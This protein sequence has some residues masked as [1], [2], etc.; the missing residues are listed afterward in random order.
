M[1][2]RTTFLLTAIS[3]GVP[4]G[5]AHAPGGLPK[6]YCEDP[7][8]WNLHDYAPVANGVF[9]LG[10]DGNIVGDC[11]GDGVPSDFD[12]HAEWAQGGATLLVES[13]D[14]V[15]SGAIACHGADAHHPFFGPIAAY[16]L[17]LGFTV[18]FFVGA[19]TVTLTPPTDPTEPVCG[20]ALVDIAGSC[21][22][23]CFVTFGPGLDGA[24]AVSVGAIASGL[25]G[26]VGHVCSPSCGEGTEPEWDYSLGVPLSDCTD[27]LDNDGD[28]GRDWI[29]LLFGSPDPGCGLPVDNEGS[30]G[31]ALT[32]VVGECADFVDNDGDGERD[33]IDLLGLIRLGGDS[34]QCSSP[35]DA[36][37]RP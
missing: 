1:N 11:N 10:R 20:D 28:G 25:M 13:G 21:V 37:E 14:G 8:E 27:G 24:Y 29:P 26:T 34:D 17:A 33:W 5:L 2:A 23:A 9:N 7:S 6:N 3:L 12:S 32:G 4:L 15:T 22:G 30:G 16:D 31:N 35:L 19:D 36:S 18:P